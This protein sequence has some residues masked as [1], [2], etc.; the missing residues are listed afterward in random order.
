MTNSVIIIPIHKNFNELTKGEKTSLKRTLDVFKEEDIFLIISES[1]D[2]LNFQF[3]LTQNLN[4][5]IIPEVH[6][7]D[8]NSYS[9]LLMSSYFYS[10]FKKYKWMLICQLDTY[11]F[12]NELF[13]FTNRNDYFFIG[14]PVIDSDLKDWPKRSWVGNGGLSLRRIDI[15]FEISLKLENLKTELKVSPSSLIMSNSL[16]SSLLRMVMGKIHKVKFNKFLLRYFLDYQVNED[17]FWCLWVPSFYTKFKS[18]DINT[19]AKFSFEKFS[20]DMYNS[21][22]QLPM[23]CHA[24]E[25]YNPEF[26]EKHIS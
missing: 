17:I 19:A 21:I 4:F 25:K 20:S 12:R 6:F 10:L 7:R 18:S 22:H 23:G 3:E 15:C 24:W 1:L 13:Y 8:I 2:I 16:F 5:T 9:K 11:I 14:A 26:W